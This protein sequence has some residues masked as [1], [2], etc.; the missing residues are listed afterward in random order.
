MSTS[1]THG[2]HNDNTKANVYVAVIMAKPSELGRESTYRPLPATPSATI[3]Y[4]YSTRKPIL[5]LMTVES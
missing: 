3:Y 2:G 4:Y 1:A 5:S